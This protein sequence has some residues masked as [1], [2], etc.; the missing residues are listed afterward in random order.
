MSD[1]PMN[2]EQDTDGRQ[3][4]TIVLL[5]NGEYAIRSDD[6]RIIQIDPDEYRAMFGT[7][8]PSPNQA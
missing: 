3:E 7:E 4:G 6:G 2:N 5:S 1:I 8:R